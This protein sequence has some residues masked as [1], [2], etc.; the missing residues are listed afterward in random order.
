MTKRARVTQAEIA[1]AIRA[2]KKEGLRIYGVRP[3]GTVLVAEPD[4]PV[5]AESSK[6]ND[7]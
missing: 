5:Q 4:A 2:A 6:W 3:D 7:D 1:R